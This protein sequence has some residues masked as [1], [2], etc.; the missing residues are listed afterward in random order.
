MP[1]GNTYQTCMA[2]LGDGGEGNGTS[3][4]TEELL[5][6]ISS[7]YDN[8]SSST[9]NS[10]DTLFLIYAASIVFFMQAGFAMI[11]AGCVRLNNVQNTLLKNLLDACGASLGFY[12]IGY[13]FAW[14]GSTDPAT[15]TTTFI[16]TQNFFLVGVEDE[17]FWLF[18][19][20]FCA[21]S[22]TIVAGALAERCQ[23]TAYLA[24]S[25]VLAA[26]VYPVVVHSIWSP[27]GFLSAT[28]PEDPLF[29]VGVVD[30]A[31]S[32][33]VHLTGGATALIATL[34]LGPRTGRFYDLRGKPL[35]K[36]KDF[37]GH[38]LSLQMLGVF[39]LWFGWYGFN[40]GS[41]IS[42]TTGENY[43]IA[44][45]A[46][47]CTTLGGAAGAIMTLF[48]HTIVEE[49]LTGEVKF[50]LQYAMNGCL[51][52]LVS[53]TAGC[54]VIESW[55]SV[56]IGLVSGL[57]YLVSSKFLVKRRID[58]AVDAIPVHMVNGIWGCLSVGFFAEPALMEHVY[59][60][61]EHVGWF[62]SWGRGSID[63]RLL[64]CQLIGCL[65]VCGWI[66][67]T[68]AP[69]FW[70]LHYLGYLRADTLEEVVGLDVEYTGGLMDMH[71]QSQNEAE[72]KMEDYVSEYLKRRD[73]RMYIK[74]QYNTGAGNIFSG[75]LNRQQARRSGG[76][77]LHAHSVHGMSVLRP[78]SQG[79]EAL[80]LN[81]RRTSSSERLS[82][83]NRSNSNETD[84]NNVQSQPESVL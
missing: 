12:S 10:I 52:G 18:Q 1:T 46:A 67:I 60:S 36:A 48:L 61:S 70:F 2:E 76:D 6:C 33:V 79:I 81:G 7:K 84:P 34:I 58:D 66:T 80:D 13:A 20:A 31:G 74:K 24:Y 50:N 4:S 19:F 64:A 65:F 53:V 55:A 26:F 5:L 41:T 57:L 23:M 49:R 71:I 56:V 42:I 11:S 78:N 43:L 25:L 73:E 83:M 16:G 32:S 75:S 21:T 40:A 30:F 54:A 29:G 38:S 3:P 28:K 37:P 14:G 47:I 9:D 44:S 68:M 63:G 35:E 27:S 69:F 51:S 15:A 82:A 59:G 17:S 45:H 72:A 39:I 77:D 22:A 8:A 62:Y